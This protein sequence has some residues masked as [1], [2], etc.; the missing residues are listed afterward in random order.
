MLVVYLKNGVDTARE[1][2]VSAVWL[3]GRTR[4]LQHNRYD[5]TKVYEHGQFSFWCFVFVEL[6][7]LLDSVFDSDRI[8][9]LNRQIKVLGFQKPLV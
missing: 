5:P 3:P 7:E 2:H 1:K 6:Q 4:L 8:D 9:P